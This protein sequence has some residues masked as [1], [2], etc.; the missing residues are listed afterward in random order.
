VYEDAWAETITVPV[1]K[2]DD[3][4]GKHGV[5]IYIKIDTEGWDAHVLA[6]LSQPVRYISFEYVPEAAHVTEAAIG[7]LARL[8]RYELSFFAEEK[9]KPTGW[10]P[11]APVWG[12]VYAVAEQNAPAKAIGDAVR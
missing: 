4:I 11:T 7:E 1:I 12:D 10:P 2:L 9:W 3:L 5:P 8:G 6:G